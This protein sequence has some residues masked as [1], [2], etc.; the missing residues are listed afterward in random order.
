MQCA[1]ELIFFIREKNNKFIHWIALSCLRGRIVTAIDKKREQKSHR[2]FLAKKSPRANGIDRMW[3]GS[4]DHNHLAPFFAPVSLSFF[5]SFLSGNCVDLFSFTSRR[6]NISTPK[7][8][9]QKVGYK[10]IWFWSPN[11]CQINWGDL[12]RKIFGAFSKSFMTH[13]P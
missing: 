5:F 3:R 11:F 10:L 8:N 9:G 1:S 13:F 6:V 12:Y 4:V 2:G 7:F